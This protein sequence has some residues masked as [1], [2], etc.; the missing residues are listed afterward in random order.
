MLR[1]IV[2]LDVATRLLMGV[3]AQALAAVLEPEVGGVGA[4]GVVGLG[5]GGGKAGVGV[6]VG[7]GM[8]IQRV[9]VQ[10]DGEPLVVTPGGALQFVEAGECGGGYGV[11]L[12]KD[13]LTGAREVDEEGDAV[14]PTDKWVVEFGAVGSEEHGVSAANEVLQ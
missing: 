12:A 2:A 11:H 4:V 5:V 9:R 13:G 1:P 8:G 6:G 14:G 3:G 7:V 10:L